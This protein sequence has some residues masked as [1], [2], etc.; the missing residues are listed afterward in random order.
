MLVERV[1]PR[2]MRIHRRRRGAPASCASIASTIPACS[3]SVMSS[4]PDQISRSEWKRNSHPSI[5]WLTAE[6]IRFPVSPARCTWKAMSARMKAAGSPSFSRCASISRRSSATSSAVARGAP[7][8]TMPISKSQRACFRSSRFSGA[9]VSSIRATASPCRSTASGVSSFTRLRS[10]CEMVMSPIVCSDCS[11]SRTAGRPT[12]IAVHQ[13]VLGRKHLARSD[14][15]RQDQILHPL[16]H[17][18]RQLAPNDLVTDPSQFVPRESV[19]V[20]YVFAP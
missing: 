16:E 20:I 14:L 18:V 4:C 9:E 15:A 6:R 5:A 1:R 12:P 3:A 11:A 10:P 8:R 17:L 2:E 7:T 19:D 13:L